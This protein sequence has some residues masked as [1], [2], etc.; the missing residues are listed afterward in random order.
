MANRWHTN[1][2]TQ[3][4]ASSHSPHFWHDY[5]PISLPSLLSGLSVPPPSALSIFQCNASV[6]VLSRRWL[7]D[8]REGPS[9]KDLKMEAGDGDTRSLAQLLTD[10]VRYLPSSRNGLASVGPSLKPTSRHCN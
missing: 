8:M 3:Q 9:L 5:E 6:P 7:K 10:Q 4:H 1:A 2:Q